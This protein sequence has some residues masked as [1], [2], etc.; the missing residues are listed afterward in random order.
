MAVSQGRA[1]HPGYAALRSGG[2]VRG[3]LATDDNGQPSMTSPVEPSQGRLGSYHE[4]VL[5]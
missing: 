5:S 3:Q 4:E 2:A 1:L